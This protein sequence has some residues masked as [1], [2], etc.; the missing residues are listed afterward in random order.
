[1]QDLVQSMY[2][3]GRE[4]RDLNELRDELVAGAIRYARIRTDW[5]FLDHDEKKMQ[6]D[7]RTRS[8]NAL[9][10]SCNSVSRLMAKSGLDITWREKLGDNRKAIGDFACYIHAY[11][12]I[13]AR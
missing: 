3:Q 10:S 2:E 9:I 11:L 1:M 8:H 13:L 6:N 7:A 12:G 4:N 5:N